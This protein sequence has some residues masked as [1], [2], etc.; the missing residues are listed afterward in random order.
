MTKRC[1]FVNVYNNHQPPCLATKDDECPKKANKR[2]IGQ[3]CWQV[4][5]SEG[6]ER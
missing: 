6:A 5:Q 1:E 4:K 2:R 3:R